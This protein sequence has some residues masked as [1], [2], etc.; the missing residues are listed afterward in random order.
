[1]MVLIVT[2]SKVLVVTIEV[3][4]NTMESS[5][6]APTFVEQLVVTV[7]TIV[8]LACQSQVQQR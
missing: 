8:M 7:T 6:K 4:V 3:L 1:M 5:D 2:T